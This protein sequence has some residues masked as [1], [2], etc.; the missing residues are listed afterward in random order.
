MNFKEHVEYL[1]RKLK[2]PVKGIPLNLPNFQNYYPFMEKGHRILLTSDVGNNK[3][4]FTNQ[5]FI[6]DVLD[7]VN[8]NPSIKV[9]VYYFSIELNKSIILSR[10]YNFL[11]GKQG[12]IYTVPELNNPSKEETLNDIKS[13]KPYFDIIEKN[14]HLYDNI[15][16]PKSIFD[17]MVKEMNKYG[18]LTKD[19]NGNY[20]YKYHDENTYIIVITDTI[21]ALQEDPGETQFESIKK[22]SEKYQ[23]MYLSMLYECLI[24]DIQQ[25]DNSVRNAQFSNNGSK[26][27]EK[28]EPSLGTLS[29]VK[30]TGADHTL[31]L[32]LYKP[33][34]YG[35]TSHE[36]YPISLLGDHY[37][38]LNIMKNNFGEMGP[39]VSTHL[40]CHADRGYFEELPA[41]TDKVLLE[42]FMKSKG[43]YKFKVNKINDKNLI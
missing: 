19:S 27:E 38:K 26:I 11:L 12:R 24:I 14:F 39:G 41:A 28:H 10:M 3:T 15:R 5:L 32:S 16:T 22:W 40:Y 29:T 33:N 30:T 25:Q 20:S 6:L 18:V 2:N 35:I 7:F 8:A 23:K 31:V 34:R 37:I 1:E 21:N 42:N 43:I 17:F 13:L 4:Q 36:G 9:E